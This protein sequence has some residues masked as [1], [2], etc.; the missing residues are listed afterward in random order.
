D[1]GGSLT[2]EEGLEMVHKDL[3]NLVRVK[4]LLPSRVRDGFNSVS[5]PSK[6]SF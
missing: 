6:I 3:F 5:L 4:V 1:I 2:G